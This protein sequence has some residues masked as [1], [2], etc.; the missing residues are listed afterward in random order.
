MEPVKSAPGLE[1]KLVAI[2][3]ADI[4]G[5]SS[6]MERDEVATLAAL[7]ELRELSDEIISNFGGRITSTAGDSVIAEFS[8]VLSAVEAAVNIQEQSF[9]QNQKTAVKH[10]LWF[11]IG[12]N[13]GDVMVKGADIFGDGVNVASR[14]EG[15]S[16]VGGIAVSRGVFD[17]VGKQTAYVFDELGMKKVKNIAEPID[18]YAIRFQDGKSVVND[19]AF[20]APVE[21]IASKEIVSGSE[22]LEISLW[23]TVK[24]SESS[25]EL[26]AYLNAFPDGAFAEVAAMRISEL[27]AAK[28]D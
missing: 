17:Y 10:P 18:A 20:D 5:F 19:K 16:E 6:H 3:A 12:L 8:S 28:S 2:L 11:R 23:E 14:L 9:V 26:Q 13:V 7:S 24:D 27:E 25:D 22:A 4:V 15:V 21:K 1:R